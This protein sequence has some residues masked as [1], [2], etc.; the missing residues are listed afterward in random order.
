MNSLQECEVIFPDV[1]LA[2]E[3]GIVAWSKDVDT[4]HLYA[5]YSKGIFPWPWPDRSPTQA[6]SNGQSGPAPDAA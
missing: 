3:N 2:D 4:A 5:A 6:S 1:E